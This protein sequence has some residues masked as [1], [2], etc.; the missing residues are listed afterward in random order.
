MDYF[1]ASRR[2]GED[3]ASF[4]SRLSAI[5]N[6]ADI[7]QL[8]KDENLLFVFLAGD[9]DDEIRK[10]VAHR[11][12][13]S[14]EELHLI[15]NQRVQFL[16]ED[17]ALA[18]GQ[19]QRATVAAVHRQQRPAPQRQQRHTHQRRS[20]RPPRTSA[21]PAAGARSE[22]SIVGVASVVAALNTI[23]TIALS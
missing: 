21:A 2:E 15:V 7:D 3:S 6:E 14:I 8:G 4:L 18:S 5:A 13:T 20:A 17:D 12:S 19:G 22:E 10:L 23:Q 16:N 1:R 9:K 11:P